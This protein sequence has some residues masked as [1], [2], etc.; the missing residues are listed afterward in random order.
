MWYEILEINQV[1]KGKIQCFWSCGSR[2]QQQRNTTFKLYKYLSEC[3]MWAQ[4]CVCV[5]IKVLCFF[6]SN[7]GVKTRINKKKYIQAHKAQRRSC[8]KKQNTANNSIVSVS[9]E[10]THTHM[11][12][13]QNSQIIKRNKTTKATNF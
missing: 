10:H 7:F 12:I 11:H 5:C 2:L 9:A 13:K 6:K 1:Y 3:V 4:V 8:K